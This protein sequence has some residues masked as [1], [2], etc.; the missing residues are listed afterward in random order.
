LRVGRVL[1]RQGRNGVTLL[2]LPDASLAKK[3][4]RD[5][6]AFEFGDAGHVGKRVDRAM[7]VVGSWRKRQGD[8]GEINQAPR[9]SHEGG[10]LLKCHLRGGS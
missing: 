5:L 8:R 10:G 3:L 7:R 6:E 4:G 1:G 2:A 9:V